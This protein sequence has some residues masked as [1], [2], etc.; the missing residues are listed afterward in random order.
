M[1]GKILVTGAT[2]TV[3]RH[4][5]AGLLA[6]G[7]AVVAA[8][9]NATAVAGA[10][11][12]SFDIANTATHQAVFADVDR[13]YVLVPSGYLDAHRFLIPLIETAAAA[14][15]KVVLQSV[16]G[17][18]ADDELP[19]RKAE[20]ALETSGTAYVILRPNWFADNFH[21]FWGEGIKHGVIALPAG[22]G[23]SSFVDVRDIAAAAVA[24]MTSSAFDG[25][26]Y[27]LTGPQALTYAEAAANLSK[28]TGKPIRYQATN[29]EDFIAM[30]TGAGVPADFA[31]FMASIFHPVREGW[32]A[33]VTGDVEK[34]SGRKP[35]GL[36]DYA[37]D[38]REAL[39]G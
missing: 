3:G 30:L 10:E 13:A 39:N 11:A 25:K 24:A 31:G 34:L 17:V 9:R 5:V 22:T 6:K 15:V 20:I 12:R 29:D 7:E 37:H 26:A 16:M 1:T 8:T 36:A 38:H 21:M 35:T 33:R 32:T 4:V 2:G 27:E 14:G 23:A 19:Y 18:D 28:A